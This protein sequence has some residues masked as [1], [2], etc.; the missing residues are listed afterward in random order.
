[1]KKE[2]S[3]LLLEGFFL[4]TLLSFLFPLA[5]ILL[6][7]QYKYTG[8]VDGNASLYLMEDFIVNGMWAVGSI[9]YILWNLKEKVKFA[10]VSNIFMIIC[11]L[12][13]CY[14]VLMRSDILNF[15]RFIDNSTYTL[16]TILVCTACALLVRRAYL[17]K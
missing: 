7:D 12:S 11:A 15:V 10:V 1:M 5:K 16:E 9:L 13:A 8:Y 6:A 2:A 4:P 17:N 3:K 14:I